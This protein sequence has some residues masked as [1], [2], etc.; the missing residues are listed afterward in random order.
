MNAA[1]N[2]I[3]GAVKVCVLLL[4]VATLL[5]ESSSRGEGSS[6][7][8]R[9]RQSKEDEDSERYKKPFAIILTAVFL[10]VAP[11]LGRFI[12]CLLTDPVVPLLWKELKTRGKKLL[13]DKFGNLL[14]KTRGAIQRK[15]T[16]HH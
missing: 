6:S 4:I 14:D 10:S 1:T 15:S 12:H 9:S 8:G 3:T 2:I 16:D 7:R 11:V 13:Q 5:V